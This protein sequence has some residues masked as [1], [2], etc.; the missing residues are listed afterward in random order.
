MKLSHIPR[1][2]VRYWTALVLASIF[3]ANTGDFFADVLKLGHIIGL[4]I[5]AVLLGLVIYM[6]KHDQRNHEFYFWAAVIVIR[7]AATNMGD[8][9]HDLHLYTPLVL[10]VWTAALISSVFWWL[11]RDAKKNGGRFT[12]NSRM[13]ATTNIYWL[14]MFLAGTV[15]TVAGDYA[16]YG[17]KLGN[18][19]AA[20]AIGAV[21]AVAFFFGRNGLQTKYAYYWMTIAL[22]RSAGT[23]AGD[24]FAH[25]VFGLSL[26]TAVSGLI[27]VAL[28]YFWNE[29]HCVG[30]TAELTTQS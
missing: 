23:A 19:K 27:F 15:G 9:G 5:L 11:T 13:F 28:V 22:I 18:L 21:V 16:S 6:D 17:L 10:A 2:S 12:Q 20:L 29:K 3:G 14:I 7:T 1:I 26:S 4:P 30:N 24:Y 25:K 8:I